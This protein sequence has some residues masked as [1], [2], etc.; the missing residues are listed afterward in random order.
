MLNT[1]N[2]VL[3]FADQNNVL[4]QKNYRYIARDDIYIWEY[5][6]IVIMI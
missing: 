3:S 6:R 4:S 5:Q 2:T 1:V